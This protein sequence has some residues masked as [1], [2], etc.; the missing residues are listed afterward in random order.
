MAVVAVDAAPA[1]TCKVV[2][3]TPYSGGGALV[4]G[5]VGRTGCPS[6]KQT[7][8]KLIHSRPWMPDVVVA[9][10][11]KEIRNTTYTLSARRTAGH[12]YIT[13]SKAS[14]GGYARSGV[15]KAP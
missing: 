10:N 13:E 4:S 8:S 14:D 12:G 1:S 5:N 2:A 15:W 11:T 3:G 7:I 9:S 6:N